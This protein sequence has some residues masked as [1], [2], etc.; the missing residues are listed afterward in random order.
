MTR[1]LSAGFL[2]LLALIA[3]PAVRAESNPN[4]SNRY[5]EVSVTNLTPFDLTI[6]AYRGYLQS[7][8][9]PSH[10]ILTTD[11]RAGKLRA[12]DLVQAAINLKWVSEQ[13]LSDRSYLN[14]VD[15]SLRD[16]DSRF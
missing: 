15:A 13:A 8:G 7:Q 6:L 14:A 1:L 11:Y 4:P 2:V 10:Y 3:A 9:I 12:K 5:Q 16:L